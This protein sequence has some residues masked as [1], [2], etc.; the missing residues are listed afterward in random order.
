MRPATTQMQEIPS[1]NGIILFTGDKM[2]VP[3]GSL[4]CK[5]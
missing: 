3:L 1:K 4:A 5:K 2:G